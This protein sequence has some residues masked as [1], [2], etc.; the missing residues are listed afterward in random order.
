MLDAAELVRG[1]RGGLDI[2]VS[3]GV[4]GGGKAWNMSS[5]KAMG[6]AGAG[7]WLRRGSCCWPHISTPNELE[8]GAESGTAFEGLRIDLLDP[9]P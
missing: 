3:R 1:A 2:N 4:G 6:P 8:F 7:V 5:R 9:K